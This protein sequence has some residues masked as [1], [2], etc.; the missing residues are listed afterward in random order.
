MGEAVLFPDGFFVKMIANFYK[1]GWCL[2]LNF[3]YA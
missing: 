2:L 1:R 3:Q